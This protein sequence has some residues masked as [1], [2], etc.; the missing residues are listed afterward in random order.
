MIAKPEKTPY[1]GCRTRQKGRVDM[2]TILFAVDLGHFKAYRISRTPLGGS[3]ITLLESYDSIEMHGKLSDMLTDEA[4]RFAGGGKK[5]GVAKAK[6]YG[7]PHNLELEL[8]KKTIKRIT[9][10]IRSLLTKEAIEEWNLAA[11]KEINSRIL[12]GL[13]PDIKGKLAKNVTSNL[14]NFGK[15]DVLKH[16]IA[17]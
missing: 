13:P 12:D 17:E 16:F 8:E 4:G 2:D 15:G 3:K 7:E 5:N 14:T 10:D 9:K 6:G 11:P 1:N